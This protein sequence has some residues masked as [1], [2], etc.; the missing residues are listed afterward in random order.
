VAELFRERGFDAK[1][2][3]GGVEAW[4]NAGYEMAARR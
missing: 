1:A 2:L 3:Q 4:R